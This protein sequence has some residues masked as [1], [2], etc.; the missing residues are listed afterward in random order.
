MSKLSNELLLLKILENGRIY[1]ISELSQLL[2]CSERSIRTYKEDLEKA[3]V[4]IE[5][6]SGRYGG[7]FYSS[8][9]SK[10][11]FFSLDK[12][13]L[14]VLESVYSY[15]ENN[16]CNYDKGLINVIEKIR[17]Q[18]ISNNIKK[19]SLNN[20]DSNKEKYSIICDAISCNKEIEFIYKNKKQKIIPQNIYVYTNN[21]FI[22]GFNLNIN[23]IR[24]YN[25][26]D[27]KNVKK[28]Y[29]LVYA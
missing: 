12:N 9:L 15:L 7:Y 28:R 3:G 24:T 6:L 20:I 26:L 25:L 22:T 11:T 8:S 17:Y 23:E 21:F 5:S 14:N 2:E 19:G 4:F 1:K 13:D 29:V 10:D 16:N 27:I 18:I